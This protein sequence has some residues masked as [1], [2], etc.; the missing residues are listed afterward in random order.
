MPRLR[1]LR[2]FP[3]SLALIAGVFVF[4]CSSNEKTDDH[5]VA[6]LLFEKS[7]RM[8]EV[9]IDSLKNAPD[10]AALQQISINFNT[11]MT[12]LNY[13]FPPD[14]DLELNEDENDSLI[15]MHKRLVKTRL[16]RDSILM[17]RIKTDSL[18]NPEKTDSLKIQPKNN[19]G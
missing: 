16:Q 5:D 9:Y 3:S 18:N 2:F 15:R 10:S 17:N 12:T 8:I 13:E 4:S 19:P 6:H 7:V 1:I 14:T 11:K